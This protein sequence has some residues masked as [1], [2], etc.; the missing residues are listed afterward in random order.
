MWVEFVVSFCPCSDGF[1][2][3]T[4]D[5]LSLATKIQHFQIVFQFDPE[6][7]EV[8]ANSWISLKF[9]FL[10]FISYT[11]YFFLKER[12]ILGLRLNILFFSR[13]KPKNVLN[14]FLKYRLSSTTN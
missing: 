2:P 5:F 13:F 14:M 11:L 1:S 12:L 10:N 6:T 4:Q 3:G 9:L 8:R 7:V